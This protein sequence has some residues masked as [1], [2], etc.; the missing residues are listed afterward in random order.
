MSNLTVLQCDS[1][2]HNVFTKEVA[3]KAD[4]II[5]AASRAIENH[6]DRDVDIHVELSDYHKG[7]LNRE[8]EKMYRI[9]YVGPFTEEDKSNVMYMW[10]RSEAA[11]RRFDNP[12]I[13]YRGILDDPG[14]KKLCVELRKFNKL[15]LYHPPLTVEDNY[16][17]LSPLSYEQ[18]H[19]GIKDPPNLLE[20]T[21]HDDNDDIINERRG[22][23][24]S[25]TVKYHHRTK[26]FA[27]EP[28]VYASQVKTCPRCFSVNVKFKYLN[29]K[30]LNQP[31][32]LCLSCNNL[33]T[34]GGKVAPERSE[35]ATAS[36]GG[37]T[38]GF[39][40][41]DRLAG[42]TTRKRKAQEPERFVCLKKECPY[43]HSDNAEFKYL[44]NRKEDQPRYKCLNCKQLYQFPSRRTRL[45]NAEKIDTPLNATVCKLPEQGSSAAPSAV[46][47]G[48]DIVIESSAL[49]LEKHS[50]PFKLEGFR[51]LDQIE[52]AG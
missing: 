17:T 35:L 29:N 21:F 46:A 45:I 1:G 34:H 51:R 16:M 39:K 22:L 32:Y 33:F 23:L 31:R 20:E 48:N 2:A 14:M 8:F 13:D 24:G 5:S 42:K 12:E 7:G 40:G 25:N 4:E 41:G 52:E 18:D 43:C 38:A 15:P 36:L 30:K 47:E 49:H 9:E 50:Q 10:A 19:Q 28:E 27:K 6:N 3:A 37:L 26:H 11:K 44:N